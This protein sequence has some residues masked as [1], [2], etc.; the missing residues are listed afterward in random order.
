MKIVQQPLRGRRGGLAAGARALQ[1]GVGLD[2]PAL[3]VQQPPRDAAASLGTRRDRLSQRERL[4]VRLE[5]LDAEQ[6][7]AN[8]RAITPKS[9][10]PTFQHASDQV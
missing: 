6:L 1:D 8:R 5:P 3:I 7:G 10:G 4:G 9:A 2:E